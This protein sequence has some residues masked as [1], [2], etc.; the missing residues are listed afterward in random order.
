MN[1]HWN[2][3]NELVHYGNAGIDMFGYRSNH[4]EKYTGQYL[5]GDNFRFDR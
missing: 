4:D 5:L 1:I 2:K 3:G